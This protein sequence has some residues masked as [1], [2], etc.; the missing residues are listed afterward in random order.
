MKQLSCSPVKSGGKKLTVLGLAALIGGSALVAIPGAQAA[1]GTQPTYWGEQYGNVKEINSEWNDRPHGGERDAPSGQATTW[2]GAVATQGYG[3]SANNPLDYT[4]CIQWSEDANGEQLRTPSS[5]SKISGQKAKVA[6]IIAAK[7]GDKKNMHPEIA[8]AMHDLF[9]TNSSDGRNGVNAWSFEKSNNNDATFKSILNDAQGWI[10]DA[11]KYAGEYTIQPEFSFGGSDA[12]PGSVGTLEN[13]SVMSGS[14]NLGSGVN[15]VGTAIEL[16]VELN[17]PIKFTSGNATKQTFEP[18]AKPEVEVTGA[19]EIYATVTTNV[20]LPAGTVTQLSFSGWQD[21]ITQDKPV[22]IEGVAPA[23]QVMYLP[24]VTTKTSDARAVP[25]TELTDH[26]EVSG[27]P[28]GEEV[29]VTS[30]LYYNG[31]ERPTQQP[32]IPDHAEPVGTVETVVTG[33]GDYET[34]GIVVEKPGYYTWVETIEGTDGMKPWTAEYGI[35]EETSLVPWSPKVTTQISEQR[36]EP[37]AEIYDTLFIIDNKDG[38]ELTVESTLYG[39]FDHREEQGTEL[40]EDAPIV[41]T[42]T[43]TVEG[44]GEFETEALEIEERGYYFWVETI[45]ETD[46]TEPWGDEEDESPTW[47]VE[48][49][50]VVPWEVQSSSEISDRSSHLDS[51]VHDTVWFSGLPW[52]HA[53]DKGEVFM[54]APPMNQPDADG[55]YLLPITDEGANLDESDTA[56]AEL[57]MYG[58]FETM[59]ERSADIPEDAPVHDV[60]TVPAINGEVVSADF[61]EFTEPGYY[62]IV[63]SFEGSDRVEPFVSD[64][65]ISS[66]STLFPEPGEP[67]QPPVPEEPRDEIEEPPAP[68]EPK[69]PDQVAI[70]SGNPAESTAWVAGA[71]IAVAA[72]GL[73]GYLMYRRNKLA[74]QQD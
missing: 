41:G 32:D 6:N 17:G 70:D 38:K 62:T 37:G 59:P 21:R 66:E 72:V 31:D 22:S 30:T 40:S 65:G 26:I 2:I 55:Q 25:G 63:T 20:A 15:T 51:A 11:E 5:T 14:T 58:P 61:A 23:M 34:P 3:N 8:L 1:S 73:G 12:V 9:D 7:H 44:N 24:S 42:V 46:E 35:S 27:V 10:K 36:A 50:T 56:E 69:T 64:F 13:L 74:G 39:P 19:G 53:V 67:E 16:T 28:E 4:W 68:K 18:G 57:T 60:I 49:T 33:S 52:D 43:T 54:M 47:Q 45:D 48:E 29:K 71:G